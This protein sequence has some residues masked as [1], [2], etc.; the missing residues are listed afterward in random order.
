M[1]VWM[2]LLILAAGLAALFL[3]GIGITLIVG[4]FFVR[5]AVGRKKAWDDSLI[6]KEEREQPRRYPRRQAILDQNK[7]LIWEENRSLLAEARKVPWEISAEDGI[8]LVAADYW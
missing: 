6:P 3:L 8:R 2:I 5:L 7:A 1:D 4:M